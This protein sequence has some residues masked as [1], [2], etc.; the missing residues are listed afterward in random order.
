MT[1]WRSAVD[2]PRDGTPIVLLVWRSNGEVGAEAVQYGWDE[3][4]DA[5]WWVLGEGHAWDS[6]EEAEETILGWY[7]IPV[8]PCWIRPEWVGS[9]DD[10]PLRENRRAKDRHE[11]RKPA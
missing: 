10:P 11:G 5:Y 2:L 4:G 7:P 1:V 3:S 9:R 8:L 6:A